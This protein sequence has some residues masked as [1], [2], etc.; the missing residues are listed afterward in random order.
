MTYNAVFAKYAQIHEILVNNDFEVAKN[1]NKDLHFE[2]CMLNN[3]LPA[4]VA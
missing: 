2:M 4:E 3:R 1:G